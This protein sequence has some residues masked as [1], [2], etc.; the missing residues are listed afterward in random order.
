MVSQIEQREKESRNRN[1]HAAFGALSVFKEAG[2]NFISFFSL[3]SQHK[4][5]K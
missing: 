2:R 4:N 5:S 3:T 1:P